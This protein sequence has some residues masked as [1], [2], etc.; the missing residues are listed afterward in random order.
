MT[1]PRTTYKITGDFNVA[2]KA[3]GEIV[4]DADLKGSTIP[5]LIEAG[6]ITPVKAEQAPI[7][8]N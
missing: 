1:T 3:P 8:E 2:G 5:V 7:Q 4:T 6:C